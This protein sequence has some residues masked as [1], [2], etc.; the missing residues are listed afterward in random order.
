[1]EDEAQQPVYLK[2]APP[3]KPPLFLPDKYYQDFLQ[4]KPRRQSTAFI[5]SQKCAR[6]CAG[7]S[8]VAI[9]FLLFIGMLVD[10]Q[11]IYI[12]GIRPYSPTSTVSDVYSSSAKKK[13]VAALAPVVSAHC[14][15]A[16]IAYCVTLI[17][18]V[19]YGWN[20]LW[21]M[22]VLLRRRGYAD[23]PDTASPSSST[24]PTFH[25]SGDVQNYHNGGGGSFFNKVTRW[26]RAQ[27]RKPKRG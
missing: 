18:S 12:K 13:S 26:R 23:I 24:I 19:L 4:G 2:R 14:H 6:G 1:M 5:D 3:P 9:L 7:F 11:P 10:R 8:L 16:A 25:V 22:R 20:M 17:V 15:Q 21:R 27:R